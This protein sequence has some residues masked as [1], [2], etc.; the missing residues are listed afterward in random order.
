MSEI[1]ARIRVRETSGIHR[2][3]YPLT[4][5]V[6]LP[7]DTDTSSLQLAP[8][9]GVPVPL[10]VTFWH[11]GE[12]RVDFAVSL[13]PLQ[14]D[15]DYLLTIGTPAA[16]PDPLRLTHQDGDKLSSLQER[17]QVVL[18][19]AGKV[20]NVV[21]DGVP[22]LRHLVQQGVREDYS[23]E[24]SR[25]DPEDKQYKRG[26]IPL[27][28]APEIPLNTADFNIGGGLLAAWH[29]TRG[30]YADGSPVQ[31]TAEIT[32]CKSWVMLN[33]R[34]EQPRPGEIIYF[35][36][37]L[38]GSFDIRPI[39]RTI[40]DCGINGI[41][42]QANYYGAY[43][44]WFAPKEASRLIRWEVGKGH[45][46]SNEEGNTSPVNYTGTTPETEFQQQRWFHLVNEKQAVAV[47]ITKMPV[48]WQS[49]KAELRHNIYLEF[50]LSAETAGPAEFGICYHFL[51][52]VPAIA[53]ATN[54]QSILLPPIV[55]VLPSDLTGWQE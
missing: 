6:N 36:L 52:D 37:P 10:Q 27:R 34:L 38:S 14:E 33:Y 48:G 55:E 19:P 45:E 1:L 50:E 4:A 54:P 20:R 51:N 43:I 53:A 47:A 18:E 9:D 13:A 31:M 22:H 7:L 29:I 12:Y 42:G 16:I 5:Y 26:L 44:N 28:A 17:F 40:F 8:L 3:L 15:M 49:L 21:Y 25:P 2:F 46:Y 11:T 35:S 23:A 32:A 41:Y 39:T 30:I 24:V